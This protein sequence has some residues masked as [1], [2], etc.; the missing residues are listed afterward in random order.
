MNEAPPDI[1]PAETPPVDPDREWTVWALGTLRELVD[2]DMRTAR[3]LEGQHIVA[4][5]RFEPPVI[6]FALS[7]ARIARAVRLTI[8]MTERIREA[9]RARKDA[10]EKAA[11][12]VAE[13]RQRRRAQVA[14]AVAAAL[15]PERPDGATKVAA[16][17]SVTP[18]ESLTETEPLDVELDTLPID[19]IVRRICRRLG[20]EPHRLPQ[21][22]DDVVAEDEAAEPLDEPL[23]D[24]APEAAEPSADAE[25]AGRPARKPPDSS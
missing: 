21:G 10:A 17:P 16:S 8:A 14:R 1:A 23:T 4:G 24:P 22:W 6:D 13:R 3:R 9:Y 20:R 18:R 7:Q 12:E 25:E 5:N 2:I 19:E 11:V 15:G